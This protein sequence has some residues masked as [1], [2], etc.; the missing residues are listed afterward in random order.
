M[1]KSEVP[2]DPG[3][4]I[5]GQMNYKWRE[6]DEGLFLLTL[7]WKC[8]GDGDKEGRQKPV[9][10]QAIQREKTLSGGLII[11]LQKQIFICSVI[12]PVQQYIFF[13]ILAAKPVKTILLLMHHALMSVRFETSAQVLI[14]ML[15]DSML[16]NNNK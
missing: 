10:T 14:S 1:N 4:W 8:M 13:C 16:I 9:C 5:Q 6:I 2:W 7:A 12:K 15:L 11:F 3:W